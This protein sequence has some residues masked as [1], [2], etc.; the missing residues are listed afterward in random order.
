MDDQEEEQDVDCIHTGPPDPR[1]LA[2]PCRLPGAD[3]IVC[4]FTLEGAR[5]CCDCYVPQE[6]V[7]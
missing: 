3:R 7:Q 1:T 4:P 2:Q 5:E 6:A